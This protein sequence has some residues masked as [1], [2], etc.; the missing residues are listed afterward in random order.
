ML[1]RRECIECLTG[2]LEAFS[3]SSSYQRT[4]NLKGTEFSQ[5]GSVIWAR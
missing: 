4:P 1:L 2:L 5:S 3:W